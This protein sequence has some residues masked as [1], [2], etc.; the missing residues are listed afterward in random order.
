MVRAIEPLLE[1]IR[2]LE[3]ALIR[4]SDGKAS[5]TVCGAIWN[6]EE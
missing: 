2:T 1:R 6:E 4:H 5:C 3:A